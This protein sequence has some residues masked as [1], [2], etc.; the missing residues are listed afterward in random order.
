MRMR[1][2]PR[3]RMRTRMMTSFPLSSSFSSWASCSSSA[4]PEQVDEAKQV[5]GRTIPAFSKPCLCLNDTLHDPVGVHPMLFLSDNLSLNLLC[6]LQG[7]FWGIVVEPC[8]NDPAILKTVRVVNSLRIVNLLC[9]VNCYCDT[10]V[11]TPFLTCTKLWASLSQKFLREKD[12][13]SRA[14]C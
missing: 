10:S 12:F 9:V 4:S 11:R 1:T 3:M 2:T 14:G 6:S 7:L 8:L 13:A 5:Q